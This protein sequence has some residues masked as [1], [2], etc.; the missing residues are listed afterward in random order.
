MIKIFI[1]VTK[2]IIFSISLLILIKILYI[3]IKKQNIK[4]Y[5]FYYLLI[6]LTLTITMLICFWIPKAP[7]SLT[8]EISD[9]YHNYQ[10]RQEQKALKEKREQ[11]KQDKTYKQIEKIQKEIDKYYNEF[12]LTHSINQKWIDKQQKA[13]NMIDPKYAEGLMSNHKDELQNQLN[14]IKRRYKQEKEADY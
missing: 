9:E 12:P 3:R 11:Q 2:L 7:H 6:F 4:D 8:S 14:D 5:P 13:I 1:S 10:Y